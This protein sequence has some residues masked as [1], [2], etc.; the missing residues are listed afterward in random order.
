MSTIDIGYQV[1]SVP[2]DSDGTVVKHRFI[3]PDGAYAPSA[4][5]AI[6]VSGFDAISVDQPGIQLVTLGVFPVIAGAA[7]AKG[8]TIEVGVDGKAIERTAGVVVGRAFQAGVLDQDTLIT[9]HC[10]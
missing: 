1:S 8:V 3:G 9:L 2:Y 5:E 7:F 10:L 4:G 6:G